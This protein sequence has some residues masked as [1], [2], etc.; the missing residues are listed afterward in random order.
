ML[1]VATTADRIDA[2]I[3]RLCDFGLL[4]AEHRAPGEAR[5]VVVARLDDESTSESAAVA[6]RAEG[7]MAVTR[8]AEGPALAA[9][10]SATRPV[11]IADRFGICLAWSEHD[12]AGLPAMIELGPGG[13]GSGHH[14]TTRMLAE[15]IAARTR[16]GDRVLDVG[17]G[18]GVLAFCAI[19]AGAA[20]AVALDLKPEAIAATRANA[21]LN[22]MAD[23]VRA[24]STPL[25]Q[26][27][28][29]FDLV[30]ANIARAGIVASAR[31]LVSSVSSGGVLMVSGISPAQ[32]S[33][34][35]GHLQP[36]VAIDDRIDGDW[37]TLTLAHPTPAT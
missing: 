13:F 25:E 31:G 10:H 8:P 1:A 29:S 17:C 24:T 37:S 26:I 32:R 5:R 22:G 23:T 20:H 14:P 18:S 16:P 21:A 19:R 4:A 2:L 7:W 35:A 28:D 34:V 30:V 6:L 3:R 15:E 12:R 9:W 33:L 36:L 27:D 11:V